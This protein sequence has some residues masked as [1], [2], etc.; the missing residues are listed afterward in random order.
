M[1]Q[2]KILHICPLDKFIPPFIEFIERNFAFERH[3]FV[4][5]GD[6][7]KFPVQIRSNIIHLT[8]RTQYFFLLA[9]LH[10]AGKIILHS[11]FDRNIVKLLSIAPWLLRK[12]YWVMWGGDLYHYQFR[13][14]DIKG[15][16]YEKIR[17]RVIRKMGHFVTYINGD[18][19]LAQ[20][21]YGA[22]GAYHE[23]LMYPSNLYKEYVVPPKKEGPLCVL[24][25]NSADPSNNHDELF[26]KL[27]PFKDESILIYCPL[28][29]GQAEYA[30]Y[31]AKLGK[32]LFGDKFIPLLEFIPFEKYLELLGQ[33][34]IAV[35]AHKRQQAMGN[36]IT[37]LGLGKKVY[38]RNDVTP[39]AKFDELGVKVF[40]VRKFDLMPLNDDVRK[41]NQV[42]IKSHFSEAAL[43][44][45]LN[46]I[47]EG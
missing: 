13:S 27:L 7:N 30:D 28:S 21:W 26:E 23:C 43:A 14:R 22:K 34:D 38:M 24:L 41:N 45:Q 10:Q 36:T 40:D 17:A 9:Q 4:L 2:E 29:Y 35:F 19:E 5:I 12:C 33:I 25:G 32:K 20:K 8:S 18:Y 31:I 6:L 44:K 1:K 11:I 46:D 37:L 16:R 47:F 3:V 42:H 39:W 15:D